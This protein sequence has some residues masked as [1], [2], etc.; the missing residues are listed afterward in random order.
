MEGEYSAEQI[1]QVLWKLHIV[2]LKIQIINGSSMEGTLF[3]QSL[4]WKL[5]IVSLKIHIINGSS[6]EGALFSQ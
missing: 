5:H 4:L 2:Y 6:M 1:L 3:S